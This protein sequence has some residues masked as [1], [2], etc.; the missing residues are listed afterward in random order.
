[1]GCISCVTVDV[2]RDTQLAGMWLNAEER[3]LVLPVEAVGQRVEQCAKLWPVSI[4]GYNL[5]KRKNTV[6]S[7]QLEHAQHLRR[8]GHNVQKVY[9]V[10]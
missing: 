5:R 9:S 4:C 10:G 8:H 7:L 1:M 2:L 6:S 3:V